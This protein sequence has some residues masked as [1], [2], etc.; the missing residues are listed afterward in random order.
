V[1]PSLK[2]DRKVLKSLDLPDGQNIFTIQA[3]NTLGINAHFFPLLE[4]LNSH[5]LIAGLDTEWNTSNHG[6][7]GKIRMIQIAIKS[8]HGIWMRTIL[9][10][11]C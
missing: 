5:E 4:H 7:D 6:K 3:S 10:T 1:W 2:E 9:L 8:P 11:F